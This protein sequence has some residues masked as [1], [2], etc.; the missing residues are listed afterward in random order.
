MVAPPTPFTAATIFLPGG[1]PLYRV[2]SNTRAA[3]EFNPGLGAPTRFAFFGDPIVPILYAAATEDAAIC[4]TLL[5][6][7]PFSGGVLRPRS[8]Q[9]SVASKLILTRRLRLAAFLGT[10]FRRLGVPASEVTET[11]ADRYPETVK[12]A[13]AAHIAGF[14]GVVY[15]SRRCNSDRVYTLFGDRVNQSDLNIQS[16]YG[17][18]FAFAEDRDWLTDYCAPLQV[19]VLI[20]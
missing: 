13:E 15:M 12:W 17:R 10:S 16:D 8:Y 14:D 1:S 2:H 5:H 3:N 9:S 18:A 4:E 19:E 11:E 6:S 7:V 20:L